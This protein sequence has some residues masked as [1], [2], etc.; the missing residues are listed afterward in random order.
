MGV[1]GWSFNGDGYEGQGSEQLKDRKIPNVTSDPLYGF[2]HLRELYFKAD[3]NYSARFTV[4]TLWD[5][6]NQTIVSNESSEIIRFMNDAVS[7][8]RSEEDH[9]RS[10]ASAEQ[11][12]PRF[13][14]DEI[15]DP[16]YQGLTF[17]PE[18]LRSEIDGAWRLLVLLYSETPEADSFLQHSTSGSTPTSTTV[19]PPSSGAPASSSGSML[20]VLLTFTPRRCLPLWIRNQAGTLPASGH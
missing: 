3:P 17:Y 19:S 10:V 7:L 1:K 11:S 4:P 9:S 12:P 6:K 14:F 20:S 5:S 15:I 8:H 13:Q 16:K 2:S 18:D